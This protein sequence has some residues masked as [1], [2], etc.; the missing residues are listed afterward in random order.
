M[1]EQSGGFELFQPQV[2]KGQASS[3]PSRWLPR[4]RIDKWANWHISRPAVEMLG[5]PEAVTMWYDAENRRVGFK[6]AK[7]EDFS[8]YAVRHA[9][10]QSRQGTVSGR[11][12]CSYHGIPYDEPRIFP[13]RLEGEMLVIDLDNHN[14]I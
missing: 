7:K 3:H 10:K 9:G 14:R 8:A 5:E 11:R 4:V 1:G 12:F 6:P 13:A 2:H